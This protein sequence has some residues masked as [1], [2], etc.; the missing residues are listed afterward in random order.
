MVRSDDA[1]LVSGSLLRALH[2]KAVERPSP[3]SAVQHTEFLAQAGEVIRS[4]VSKH[5]R[6]DHDRENQAASSLSTTLFDVVNVIERA[7]DNAS[8]RAGRAAIIGY[9]S[10]ITS[11]VGFS[12]RSA[13]RRNA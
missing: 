11:R 5:E 8:V 1:F 3:C 4:V 12:L 6:G 10:T 13:K 9:G 7:L 2:P